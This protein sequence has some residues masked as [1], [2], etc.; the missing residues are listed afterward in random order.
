MYSLTKCHESLEALFL[1]KQSFEP[2]KT[3]I[4]S[5]DKQGTEKLLWVDR[6]VA[7]RLKLDQSVSVNSCQAEGPEQTSALI[8][9]ACIFICC[10]NH[11]S[12]NNAMDSK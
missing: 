1:K 5:Y 7:P 9:H 8:S 2:F 6:N 12:Y 10:N 4:D 11:C 3:K